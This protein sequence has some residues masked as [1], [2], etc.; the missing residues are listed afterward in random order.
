MTNNHFF[1]VGAQRSGTTYLY[2]VLDEHSEILMAKPVKPEPKFFLSEDYNKGIDFYENKY[3][4]KIESDV[5][6]LGEKSTSYYESEVVP[7]RIKNYFPEAK[8][9]FILRDPIQRALSNYYFSVNNGLEKR[10]ISEVFLEKIPPETYP[11]HISTDPFNY[12]GRGEYMKFIKKYLDCFGEKN[13]KIL[14]FER[15]IGNI[16]QVQGLYEYLEVDRNFEPTLLGQK[17]NTGKDKEVV[18]EKVLKKLKNYFQPYNKTLKEYL[19]DNL[20]EW[21]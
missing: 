14:I 19:G 11:D 4:S 7:D 2:S 21:L 12:L 13:V 9:I 6:T 18:S 10:T 8:I 5:K 3:F 16:N 17:T 1:I 15:L 20:T